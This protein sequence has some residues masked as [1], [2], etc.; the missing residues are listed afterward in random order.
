MKGNTQERARKW[1]Q[2]VATYNQAVSPED[3]Q[4]SPDVIAS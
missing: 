1:N 4:R 3:L 2:A